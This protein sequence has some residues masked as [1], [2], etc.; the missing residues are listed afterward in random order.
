MFSF[1]IYVNREDT[2]IETPQYY[3]V[4]YNTTFNH[5]LKDTHFQQSK[6]KLHKKA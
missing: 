1:L 6:N 3:E 2:N 4:Q 5:Y